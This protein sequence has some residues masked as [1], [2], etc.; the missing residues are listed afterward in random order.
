[1]TVAPDHSNSVVALSLHICGVNIFRHFVK[2]E[3]LS[4]VDFIDAASTTTLHSEFERVD[5]LTEAGLT[6]CG[7]GIVGVEVL[8]N[9]NF[10]FNRVVLDLQPCACRLFI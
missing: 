2:L 5:L 3:D 9:Y 10:A 6:S 7:C 8:F 4:T 1:M